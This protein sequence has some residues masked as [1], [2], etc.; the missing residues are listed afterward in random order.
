MARNSRRGLAAN[1]TS[2]EA[3]AAGTGRTSALLPDQARGVANLAAKLRLPAHPELLLEHPAAVDL[4]PL[5]GVPLVPLLLLDLELAARRRLAPGLDPGLRDP[6]GDER[7]PKALVGRLLLAVEE[8][9]GRGRER[10]RVRGIAKEEVH[11]H[12][13]ALLPEQVETLLEPPGLLR[14]RYPE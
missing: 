12:R 7:E 6:V 3:V 10:A 14:R 5:D 9:P 8:D 2:A 4:E 13:C 1:R 11:R